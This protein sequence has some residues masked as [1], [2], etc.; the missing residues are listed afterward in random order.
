MLPWQ[1]LGRYQELCGSSVFVDVDFPDLML[2][3]R[4][5]VLN[6]PELGAAFAPFEALGN[7][8]LLLCSRQYFQVGCDLRRV[9]SLESA[10]SSV[11][12]LA[13]ACFLFVAEV[14]ITYMPTDS[15]DA[16]VEWASSLGD[17]E[18][19][20]SCRTVCVPQPPVR[21][22]QIG[23]SG[24]QLLP[25][26]ADTAGGPRPPFCSDHV[27]PLRAAEHAAEVRRQVPSGGGPAQTLHGARLA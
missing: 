24:S 23:V 15:A 8:P 14:S 10:L 20:L 19:H 25:T 26:R 4:D 16:L 6:T 3:K 13:E 1:C 22:L 7:P 9:S 21:D 11:I 5:I 17:C 12:H 2:R 18:L 27:A